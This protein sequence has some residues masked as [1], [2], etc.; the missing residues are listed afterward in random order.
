MKKYNFIILFLMFS[1]IFGCKSNR[2]IVKCYEVHNKDSIYDIFDTINNS[3][4]KFKFEKFVPMDIRKALFANLNNRDSSIL[5]S[6]NLLL[7]V[8]N[9][10]LIDKKR[11]YSFNVYQGTVSAFYLYSKEYDIFYFENSENKYM[12]RLKAIIYSNSKSEN[13]YL[14]NKIVDQ[15]ILNIPQVPENPVILN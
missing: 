4:P 1:I 5:I 3:S 11:I 14:F 8:Q 9:D 6:D 12:I 7:K 13:L 2:I 10:Y 15:L